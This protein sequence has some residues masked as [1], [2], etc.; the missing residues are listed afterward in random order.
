MTTY[1]SESGLRVEFA[2]MSRVG[3]RE[4]NE[5]ACGYWTS[6]GG[7]C[8]VV[9]D[10]AGGHGGGDVASETTVRTLLKAF[11]SRPSLQR[12][13]VESIVAQADRAVRYARQQAGLQ[14]NMCATVAALFL[15][16]RAAKAQWA[17]VGDTRVY[18]FRGRDW[19]QLSKDH[20]VVQNLVEAGLIAPAEAR[21]HAKRNQ[22]FAALGAANQIPSSSPDRA[23]EIEDGD[24]F[25]ICTDGFWGSVCETEMYDRLL[26]AESTEEWLVRMEQLILVGEGN[27]QDNYSALAVWIGQPNQVTLPDLPRRHEQMTRPDDLI[28]DG[29]A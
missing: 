24:A 8:F 4:R 3:G 18:H 25:L 13:H 23:L 5:D 10:G 16:Q 1:L 15:D 28:T 14:G 2:T 9:S 11:A 19:R 6:A 20:S 17:N 27:Q 26:L 22:L 21:S 12:G 29:A 7:A